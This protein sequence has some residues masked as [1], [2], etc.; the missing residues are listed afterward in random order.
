MIMVLQFGISRPDYDRRANQYVEFTSDE[1]G[2]HLLKFVC[3]LTV[4][5]CDAKLGK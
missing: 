4:A 1:I 2:H 5:Y 3:H